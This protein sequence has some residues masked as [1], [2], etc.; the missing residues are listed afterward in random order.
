MLVYGID[1]TS[2]PSRRKPITVAACHLE[3]DRLTFVALETLATFPEF[4]AFL[5]RPGPWI[6]GFDFPFAHARRFID[7]IGW[8]ADWFSCMAHIAAMSRSDYVAALET[9]KAP[10]APGDREHQRAFERGT[11]AASPQKLYGVPVAKMLFE[12]APRLWQ[13]GLDLP[14]LHH[15]D[16]TR[17]GVEAY[18]GVLARRLIGRQ[19]YKTDTAAR[20]KAELSAARQLVLGRLRNTNDLHGLHLHVQAPDHLADPSD[21]DTLDALLCAAQ[22]AWAYRHVLPNPRLLDRFDPPEGWIADPSVFGH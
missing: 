12:G 14:G 16:P 10:R 5:R 7:N 2:A 20:A 19:S 6:A 18:P 21:A 1:F 4:E 15:G 11:G 3:G 22:A 17:I 13:A 8:P 9:Y